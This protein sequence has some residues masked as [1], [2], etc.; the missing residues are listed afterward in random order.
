MKISLN[1]LRDYVD[2]TL[3]PDDLAH[4]LTMLGL[5]IES[6]DRPGEAIRNVVIGKI[7]S[8][9][10]HPDA[11]KL[12]VCRT[13]V[14]EG[15]PLQIVC[16]ARNMKPGDKVPTAKT[17]GALPGGFEISRR[18][19]RG[20]ESQGMMCS[21]KELGLS[22]DHS[23]LL[24]LDAAAPIGADAV[25][26][27]GLDD[28][29]YEIEVTPNRNDWASMIGVARELAASLETTLRLP[30]FALVES[31]PEA[32]RLSSVQ[33]ENPDLC[34][35]YAGRV[36]TEV[37]VGPS[38]DWLCRRLIAAGQRPI[39]NIVDITNYVLLETGHPL[40][41]FDYQTLNENRIVVRTARAG[42]SIATL[43][44]EIR[45]LSPEMLV[46]A[47]ATRPV[48]V[49]GVMGGAET[50]VGENTTQVFL[51]SAYFA[52]V[53]IRRTAKALGMMTEASQRFQRG[54]DP[55]MARYAL[56]RAAFLMQELAGAKTALGVLDNYPR[57]PEER[58]IRLRY[59]RT[60]AMLGAEPAPETQKAYLERLGFVAHASDTESCTF[61]IPTWRH[62][63]TMEADLIEEVARL[64][65][66]DLIQ[67]TI[68]AVRH[69]EQV[70][71]PND[72][73]LRRLR[74]ALA[75]YGLSE[76]L[77][78]TFSSS[79]DV[80]AVG[81]SGAYLDMAPLQNPLSENLAAMR[82][83]LLPGMVRAVQTNIRHGRR[84][85]RAFEL[86]PVYRP[87]PERELPEQTLRL[88]LVLTGNAEEPHWS[89]PV[90]AADLY[91][92]TGIIQAVGEHFGASL[93]CD[94][95]PFDAFDPDV[96]AQVTLNGRPIGWAGSLA[97]AVRKTWD[98]E[99]PVF[100]AEIALE[101]LL[102]IPETPVLFAPIP[103]YP[104][105]LRD[106]AVLVDQS[107]PA[108]ALVDAARTAGGKL[109]QRVDVFDVYTGKQVPAG[110]KSI[111]LSL[112]FQSP[113]R[114][115]TDKATQ[116]AWDA[117]VKRLQDDFGAQLR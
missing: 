69:T 80:A 32:E 62:D 98:I 8:I 85:V 86:G 58:R 16:G 41:A 99:Q 97:P 10:P 12:V 43:D 9:D 46:I 57:P 4:R 65:G 116:K 102:D 22:D 49:A 21:G 109:L 111:A 40:H 112:V 75:G 110:K 1:W 23:G 42:E 51:E 15:E 36:L 73:R 104:P 88:G 14:G 3:D 71:A 59:A 17:G 6:V 33:I 106:I 68:P 77:G 38:P 72:A 44:G 31:P 82:S 76:L 90:R 74:R 29:I 27:L 63:C 78:M 26:H 19:M 81:L 20:I 117:I 103:A 64:Y 54:A 107:V 37:K 45:A 24:I 48:A 101:P 18:K 114:T 95:A 11:D 7:L 28:V 92:I 5:E 2:V 66:Y 83:T 108:G 87:A 34:P 47:D 93:A 113:E 52:P 94:A 60:H 84:D 100:L 55:E 115:L 70:F 67:P 39:N 56:D 89:R 30:E 105:S 53:S 50:E 13:D 79:A 96:S 91:D 35:R 25:A 61:R